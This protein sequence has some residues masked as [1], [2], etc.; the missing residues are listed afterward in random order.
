MKVFFSEAAVWQDYK[1]LKLL[2]L[3]WVYQCESLSDVSYFGSHEYMGLKKFSK[4]KMKKDKVKKKK[5]RC[6]RF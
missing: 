4:R 5:K 6:F 3:K 2:V 1:G